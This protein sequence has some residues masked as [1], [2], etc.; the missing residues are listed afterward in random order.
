MKTENEIRNKINSLIDLATKNVDNPYYYEAICCQTD[1]LMWVID[2]EEQA[3][4]P[5]DER[6]IL[7][8]FTK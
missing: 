8:V 7:N 4:K 6:R 1:I 3:D 2:Y 5:L